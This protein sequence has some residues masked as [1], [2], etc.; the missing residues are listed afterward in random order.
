MVVRT[1]VLIA[2]IRLLP[3]APRMCPSLARPWK[4][5]SDSLDRD[6]RPVADVMTLFG[7]NARSTAQIRGTTK[8][9]TPRTPASTYRVIF[10]LLSPRPPRPAGADLAG[11][12]RTAGRSIVVAIA[13]A[14]SGGPLVPLTSVDLSPA[15]AGAR[16]GRR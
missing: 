8:T 13:S 5:P 12:V 16:T 4:L 2:T 9:T 1:A 10:V 7:W 15:P 11:R 3:T 6:D 14:P